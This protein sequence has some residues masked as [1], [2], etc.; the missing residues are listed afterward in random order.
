MALTQDEESALRTLEARDDFSDLIKAIRARAVGPAYDV[1]MLAVVILHVEDIDEDLVKVEF[2]ARAR[3]QKLG[4]R[5]RDAVKG[6][7]FVIDFD[8]SDLEIEEA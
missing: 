7:D 4:K 1:R 5:L 3:E 6:T 2:D 8:V